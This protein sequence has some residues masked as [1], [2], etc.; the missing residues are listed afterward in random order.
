MKQI[1]YIGFALVP[2]LA[3]CASSTLGPP[4]ESEARPSHDV[5]ALHAQV[6]KLGRRVSALNRRVKSQASRSP[7]A[8][9]RA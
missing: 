3:G 7:V 2:L 8:T 5:A 9:R 1:A 4:V 6:R